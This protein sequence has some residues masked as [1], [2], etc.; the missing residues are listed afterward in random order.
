[1]IPVLIRRKPSGLSLVRLACGCEQWVRVLPGGRVHYGRH[2]KAC[3]V[4]GVCAAGQY[5]QRVEAAAADLVGGG[6]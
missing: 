4:G 1:M 2:A 6:A 5:G 3:G